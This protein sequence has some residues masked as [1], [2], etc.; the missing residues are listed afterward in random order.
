LLY[1]KLEKNPKFIKLISTRG[2]F[3]NVKD[4]EI[5]ILKRKQ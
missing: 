5:K 4:F 1:D 3:E 2:E